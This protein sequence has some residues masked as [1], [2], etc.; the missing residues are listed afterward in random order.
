[1]KLLGPGA[2][3]T[4]ID[5]IG[6]DVYAVRQDGTLY[7]VDTVSGDVLARLQLGSSVSGPIVVQA[8]YLLVHAGD[9][10]QIFEY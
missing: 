4:R 10:L 6:T 8:E 3:F 9:A 1:M 7:G 2:A 5:M